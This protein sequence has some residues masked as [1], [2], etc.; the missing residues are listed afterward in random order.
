M[1]HSL[2]E[3]L[4]YLRNTPGHWKIFWNMYLYV[5]KDI[6]NV[7]ESISKYQ[8]VSKR[9]QTYPNVSECIQTYSNVSKHIQTNPNVPQH[10]SMYVP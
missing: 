4:E 10:I 2:N 8:Y 6:L 1:V 7:S 5:S 3:I 9:I